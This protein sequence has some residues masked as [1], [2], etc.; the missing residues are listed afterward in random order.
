LLAHALMD[1]DNQ[2]H[3]GSLNLVATIPPFCHLGHM[4]LVIS[5]HEQHNSIT[6]SMLSLFVVILYSNVR[7]NF[8]YLLLSV[9]THIVAGNRRIAL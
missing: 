7:S 9:V 6:N 4:N 3:S 2:F 5:I 8:S 1:V